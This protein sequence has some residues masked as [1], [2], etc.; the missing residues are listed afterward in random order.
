MRVTGIC[1]HSQDTQ[2]QFE[3]LISWRCDSCHKSC[4]EIVVFKMTSPFA[5]TESHLSG[6]ARNLLDLEYEEKDTRLKIF[7]AL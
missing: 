4:S 2:S 6:A 7:L 1:G 5:S 3:D